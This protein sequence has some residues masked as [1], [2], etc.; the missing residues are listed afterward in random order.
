VALVENEP[1]LAAATPFYGQ[2]RS[3]VDLSRA[4]AAVLAAYAELD[5][6]VNATR[7]E[8]ESALEK[9]KLAHEVRTFPGVDHAFMN[10]T[11]PRY[12]AVQATAA[13]AAVLDWFGRYLR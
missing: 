9:A 11:G 2:V 13:Y 3:G 7:E 8:A 6:R 10:D 5:A 4:R 1:R 12:D